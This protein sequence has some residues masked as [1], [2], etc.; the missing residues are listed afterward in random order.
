MCIKIQTQVFD[1]LSF[2]QVLYK[3]RDGSFTDIYLLNSFLIRLYIALLL[4]NFSFFFTL[5][6]VLKKW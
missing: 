2:N 4:F 3:H 1:R 6:C 5:K